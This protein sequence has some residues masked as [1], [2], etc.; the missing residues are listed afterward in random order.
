LIEEGG[1]YCVTIFDIDEDRVARF[2]WVSTIRRARRLE[3]RYMRIV[4]LERYS[5]EID[6]ARFD[7]R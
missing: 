7:G 5:T 4:D 1:M 2:F 6:Y 3:A